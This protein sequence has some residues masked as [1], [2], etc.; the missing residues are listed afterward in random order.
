MLQPFAATSKPLLL[1]LETH[2][3]DEGCTGTY[4]SGITLNPFA[5][6]IGGTPGWIH[7]LQVSL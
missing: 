7:M 5:L 3:A 1:F 4:T 6:V 2:P